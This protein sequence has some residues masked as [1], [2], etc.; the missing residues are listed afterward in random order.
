LGA[1]Q[2]DSAPISNGKW[3]YISSR[4]GAV[5]GRG[6]VVACGGDARR[7]DWRNRQTQ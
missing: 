2:Y 5:G 7:G 6:L 1:S 4:P 3:F